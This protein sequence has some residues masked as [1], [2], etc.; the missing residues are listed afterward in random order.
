MGSLEGD[1]GTGVGE[2]EKGLED[3][4]GVSMERWVWEVEDVRLV[5]VVMEDMLLLADDREALEEVVQAESFE[6][7]RDLVWL[8]RRKGLDGRR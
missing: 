2:R 3:V 6:P 7:C 5:L 4:D 8:L 1:I